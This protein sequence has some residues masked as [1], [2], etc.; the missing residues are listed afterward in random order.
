M[1]R[2]DGSRWAARSRE[3][4]QERRIR[5]R[6]RHLSRRL[7]LRGKRILDSSLF[8]TVF[9]FRFRRCQGRNR[10]CMRPS[11]LSFL[12]MATGFCPRIHKPA[13]TEPQGLRV[14]EDPSGCNQDHGT[15]CHLCAFSRRPLG[16]WAPKFSSRS[17][18]QF[19]C[20]HQLPHHHGTLLWATMVQTKI[21]PCH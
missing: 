2:E 10:R 9:I 16:A 3:E 11:A 20:C 7:C 1:P 18:H 15:E 5:Q 19:H 13:L 21:P 8:L 12:F 6:F 4:L 17:R 14:A